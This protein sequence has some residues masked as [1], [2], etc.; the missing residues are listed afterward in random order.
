VKGTSRAVRPPKPPRPERTPRREPTGPPPSTILLLHKP[1]GVLSQFTDDAGRPTLA[2]FVKAPGLYAAGRLDF[3]SEGLLVLTDI[4]WVKTRLTDAKNG[5]E[6]T[7]WVQVEVEGDEDAVPEESALELLRKGLELADGPTRPAR[8]FRL[9]PASVPALARLAPRHPAV[10]PRAGHVATWLELTIKEGRNRQVRRMC[11]AVGLPT[12]R[13]VRVGVGP[14]KLDGLGPGKT[15]KV[16]GIPA[17][18]F[19]RPA[20]P[21]S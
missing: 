5:I 18:L 11:A 3:D 14:W 2:D 21:R 7:Y 6:K 17:E 19:R 16:E 8:A 12:L 4:P 13:L 15:R 10:R 9:D 20:A 1:Y